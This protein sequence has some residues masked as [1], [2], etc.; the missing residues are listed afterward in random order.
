MPFVPTAVGYTHLS[1]P[2]DRMR[3]A[4]LSLS[5]KQA[6]YA[7]QKPEDLASSSLEFQS[8][9]QRWYIRPLK[10]KRFFYSFKFW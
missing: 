1:W 5:D 7:A 10:I 8:F 4:L 3:I 2:K 9:W 6:W